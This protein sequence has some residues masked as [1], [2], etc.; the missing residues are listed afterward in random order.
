MYA[1]RLSELKESDSSNIRIHSTRLKECLLQQIS[2]LRAKQQGREVL[3]IFQQDVGKAIKQA[4]SYQNDCEAIH[5]VRAA[6]IVRKHIFEN[7]YEFTRTFPQDCEADAIPPSLYALVRKILQGPSI[8]HQSNS[9]TSKK[10]IALGLSQLLLFNTAKRTYQSK[11]DAT[12]RHNKEREAP[13]P[14]YL[15]MLIHSK[16]RKKGLIDTL[17]G[18]GLCISYNRLM[19]ISTDM[20]NTVCAQYHSE[21]VVCPPKM[22]YGLFTCSAIDNI[23]HNPSSRT[24]QD[25]FHGTAISLMQFPTPE[26]PGVDRAAVSIDPSQPSE[27][28]IMP[29]PVSYTMVPP[30]ASAKDAVA[31]V[32]EGNFISDAEKISEN[33]AKE[34]QWLQQLERLLQSPQLADGDYISWAAFHASQQIQTGRMLT[35][36]TLLPLFRENAHSTCMILHGMNVIKAAINHLHP[37]QIPVI[38]LDQPLYS[39]AKQVQWSWPGSHGEDKIVIMMGGLHIEMNLLKLL[40]DW[41]QG[42][43]WTTAVMQANITSTGWA[44]SL[45]S[46][47]PVTRTR[48]G[49]Q[50]T[51]AS[52]HILRQQAYEQY[53]LQECEVQNAL[54]FL[55]WRSVQ[56]AEKPQFRYWNITLQLQLMMLQFVRSLQE[57]DFDMYVH[58]LLQIAP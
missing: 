54:P 19:N 52:L 36:V 28:R 43:G 46:D 57:A 53:C 31:P 58:C 42:S 18:L 12:V 2:D 38:A 6:Q 11:G 23:D 37:G 24:A 34:V 14:I 26:T 9:D 4:L 27:K 21:D 1:T 17:H 55:E 20:A 5:L 8:K 30:A 44:E 40:G 16:T 56:C 13:L 49:H 22:R 29:L 7:K 48:Y 51:A 45:L 32:K 10:R 3:L 41:L 33:I 25:S 47:T 39:L 15:S 50:V 35:Q